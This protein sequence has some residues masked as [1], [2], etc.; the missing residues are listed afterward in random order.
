MLNRITSINTDS[1]SSLLL[2]PLGLGAILFGAINVYDIHQEFFSPFDQVAPAQNNP[3]N[4]KNREETAGPNW[5]EN[6]FLPMFQLDDDTQPS[7]APEMAPSNLDQHQENVRLKSAAGPQWGKT[8]MPLTRERL[9]AYLNSDPQRL[10][11]NRLVIE[12]ISVA[13]P[14][15]PVEYREIEYQ[16]NRYRQWTAP[17]ENAV[18]WHFNSAPLGQTGNTVL[19]GHSSGYNEIF[20]YLEDVENGDIIHV[21]SGNVRF[22]YVVANVMILK[23][24]WETLDKRA[25]NAR[26]INPSQDERL[27][28][29]SC[30]PY[31]SN[32]HR[33]IVVATPIGKEVLDTTP[34]IDLR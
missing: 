10:I 4:S 1:L 8:E 30:W 28:L 21:F 20:R 11:P 6:S 16:G 34:I 13:A 9:D 2:I 19:N 32:S 26:W 7:Y 25:E 23:E 15:V 14:V 29:I 33:V 17:K 5:S 3:V 24:R 31:Q 27:T 18:G 12:S 22:D